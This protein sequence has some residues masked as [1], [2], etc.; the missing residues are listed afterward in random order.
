MFGKFKPPAVWTVAVV[1]F[2]SVVFSQENEAQ[3]RGGR[4]YFMAGASILNFDGFNAALRAQNYPAFSGNL[5]S[6]GGGGHGIIHRFVIGG[7][8]HALITGN[9]DFTL[10]NRNY[11]S[12]LE[13]GYAAFNVGYQIIRHHGFALYPLIG[14]GG[15]SVSLKISDRTPTSFD[16]V[17]ANPGRY[18]RLTTGGLLMHASV[19]LD[20]LIITRRTERRSRGFVLG[21]RAGYNFVPITGDW[22]LEE[23]EAAGGPEIDVAGPYVRLLIGGGNNRSK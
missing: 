8:A 14:L 1:S 20:Y 2:S 4:G 6:L 11:K 13:T 5:F 17:L 3:T 12:S 18:A 21:L 9:K 22:H 19:G 23:F 16:D 7:E 10:S 15:G